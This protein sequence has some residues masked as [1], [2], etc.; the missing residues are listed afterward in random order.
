SCGAGRGAGGDTVS[1]DEGSEQGGVV[2]AFLFLLLEEE[3][4]KSAFFLGFLF[5]LAGLEERAG[6]SGNAA[7]FGIRPQATKFFDVP[8]IFQLNCST[9]SSLIAQ[10]L[11]S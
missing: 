7:P 5:E 3:A 2:G 4:P 8:K 11:A 10:T 9:G 6:G 1:R